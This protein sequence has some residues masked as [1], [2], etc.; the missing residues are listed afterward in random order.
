MHWLV[1]S[2]NYIKPPK[3][4]FEKREKDT[5]AKIHNEDSRVILSA[6][7]IDEG[8]PLD[9]ALCELDDNDN[10]PSHHNPH[11][12]GDHMRKTFP[13]NDLEKVNPVTVEE[14]ENAFQFIEDTKGVNP[15]LI[16]ISKRID[17]TSMRLRRLKSTA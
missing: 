15:D 11:P 13:L 5:L 9:H 12:N 7:L 1:E 4:K 16:L 14:L 8:M 3:R 2:A 10:I 6:P 17:V